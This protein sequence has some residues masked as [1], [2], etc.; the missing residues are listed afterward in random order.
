MVRRSN[1]PKISPRRK[2]AS[3]ANTEYLA[4]FVFDCFRGSTSIAIVKGVLRKVS[5]VTPN[6]R[7]HQEWTFDSLK[8]E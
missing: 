6:V 4:K 7:L 1:L 3:L 2:I 8:V 5:A